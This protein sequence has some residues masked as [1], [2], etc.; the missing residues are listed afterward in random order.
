MIK[1][2]RGGVDRRQFLQ[3]TAAAGLAASLPFGSAQAAPKKGGTFNPYS[4]DKTA[5]W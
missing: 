2:I 3:T 4:P 1:N 5:F